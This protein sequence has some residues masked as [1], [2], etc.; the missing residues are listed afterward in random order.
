MYRYSNLKYE[1]EQ[2]ILITGHDRTRGYY[3]LPLAKLEC[4]TYLHQ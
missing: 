3:K 4:I 2:G 1:K